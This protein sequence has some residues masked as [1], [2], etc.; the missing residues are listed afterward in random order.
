MS[1][2]LPYLTKTLEP[3]EIILLFDSVAQ[4]VSRRMLPLLFAPLNVK[5]LGR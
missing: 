3:L 5:S 2:W 4:S 1:L